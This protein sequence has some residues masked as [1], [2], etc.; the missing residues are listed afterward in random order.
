MLA[1]AA[2]SATGVVGTWVTWRALCDVAGGMRMDDQDI[3]AWQWTRAG[4][5]GTSWNDKQIACRIK[6]DCENF[7]GKP[8]GLARRPCHAPSEKQ[9][10][11][12]MCGVMGQ[13]KTKVLKYHQSRYFSMLLT[14]LT[15]P[16]RLSCNNADH[17]K[18]LLC[19]SSQTMNMPAALTFG[20]HGETGTHTQ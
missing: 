19:S 20:S 17:E 5:I 2:I 12:K 14:C 15:F 7:S 9:K 18:M 13:H 11:W 4:M 1:S 6:D 3:R 10:S 16:C 8:L